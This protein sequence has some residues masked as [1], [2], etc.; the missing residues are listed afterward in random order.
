MVAGVQGSHLYRVATKGAVLDYDLVDGRGR[1]GTPTAMPGEHPLVCDLA[2]R[3]VEGDFEREED[4]LKD[5]AARAV[6]AD[7]P[8]VRGSP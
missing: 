8:E 2:V 7:G 5:F 6:E 1:K 4:V 3:L